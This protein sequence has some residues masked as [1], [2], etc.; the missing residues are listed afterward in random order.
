MLKKTDKIL[1]NKSSQY[2]IWFILF[3]QFNPRHG[4]HACNVFTS[5]SAK[6]FG[7]QVVRFDGDIKFKLGVS[8]SLGFCTLYGPVFVPCYCSGSFWLWLSNL[9]SSM[10][11]D[12]NLYLSTIFLCKAQLNVFSIAIYPRPWTLNVEFH[13]WTANPKFFRNNLASN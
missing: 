11:C 7:P 13:T 6:F 5:S 9:V 3:W 12:L 10:K 8:R 1:W 2:N 4:T